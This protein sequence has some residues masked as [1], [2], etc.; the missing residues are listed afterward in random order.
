MPGKRLPK[1]RIAGAGAIW[2]VADIPEPDKVAVALVVE[3]DVH[4]R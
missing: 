1:V 4:L 3:D 2:P